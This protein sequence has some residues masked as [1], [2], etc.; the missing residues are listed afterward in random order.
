MNTMTSLLIFVTLTVASA[1]EAIQH[2]VCWREIASY[3]HLMEQKTTNE[4]KHRVFY[5][6]TGNVSGKYEM[7]DIAYY[8]R[9]Q[10]IGPKMLKECEE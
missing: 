10:G 2:R 5:I 9:L 4:K 6:M 3:L 8:V 1:T 7:L